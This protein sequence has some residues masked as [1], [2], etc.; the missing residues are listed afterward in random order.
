[1]KSGLSL[2]PIPSDTNKAGSKVTRHEE[3]GRTEEAGSAGVPQQTFRSPFSMIMCH[4]MTLNTHFS[5]RII[6]L[7]AARGAGNGESGV[8]KRAREIKCFKHNRIRNRSN[9]TLRTFS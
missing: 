3:P 5:L 8:K 9:L 6:Y 4:I 7:S 1:M 2:T